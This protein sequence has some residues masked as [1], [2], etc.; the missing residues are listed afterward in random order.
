MHL[1]RETVEKSFSQNVLKTNGWNLQWVIKVVKHFSYIQNFPPCGLS[2]I[3][4]GLYTLIKLCNLMSSS[5]K[6]L[7]QFSSDFTWGLLSKGY[8]QFVQM[9]WCHWTS[10]SSPELRHLWVWILVYSIWDSKSTK[11]VQMMILERQ[12][13]FNGMVEFVS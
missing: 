1:Y 8:C 4:P 5:L 11:F 13:N 2:A 12:L 7:Q 9:V 10:T 3:A 6:L